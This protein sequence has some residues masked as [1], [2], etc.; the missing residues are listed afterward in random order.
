MNFGPFWE[1][2]FSIADISDTFCRI[3]TK[4][5]MVRGLASGHIFPNL[6]NFI[7]ESGD[8]ICGDMHQ[9]VTD[10]LALLSFTTITVD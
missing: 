3:A 6:V 5:C 10:A 7:L 8:A 4:F 1:H 9:L 2:T